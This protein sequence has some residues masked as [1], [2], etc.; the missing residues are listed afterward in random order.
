MFKVNNK[1]TR[2]TP[3]FEHVIAGWVGLTR[4]LS[5][6]LLLFQPITVKRYKIICKI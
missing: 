2:T 4:L 3:K 5:V 1:D 6:S